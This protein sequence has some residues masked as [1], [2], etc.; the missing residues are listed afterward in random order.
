MWRQPIGR[1]A[2][3]GYFDLSLFHG[4]DM[5][6]VDGVVVDLLPRKEAQLA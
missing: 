5:P 1:Y 2:G 3:Y 6:S 4:L